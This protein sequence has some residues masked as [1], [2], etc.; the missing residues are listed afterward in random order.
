MQ[1]AL[2]PRKGNVVAPYSRS[3]F[4][5]YQ[6]RKQLKALGILSL[7]LIAIFFLLSQ[8][9]YS[10]TGTAAAPIG[11][12]SFVIVTVFDRTLYSDTYL[13]KIVKNREDYAQ[14][15]GMWCR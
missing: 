1:F 6:R 5:T 12:A 9:F 14:R 13:Q 10:G 2:P 4:F 7:A 11:A 3:P 15:H 8:L